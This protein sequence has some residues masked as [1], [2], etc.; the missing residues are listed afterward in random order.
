MMCL[1]LGGFVL[2]A[3]REV[4]MLR[5][6]AGQVWSLWDEVL[7]VDTRTLAP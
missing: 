3:I 5:L 1:Q 4:G 2:W 7:P 6:A